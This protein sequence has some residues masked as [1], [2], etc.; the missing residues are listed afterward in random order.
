MVSKRQFVFIQIL[1]LFIVFTS[2]YLLPNNFVFAQETEYLYLGGQIVGID[3]SLN[4]IE[5]VSKSNVISQNGYISPF[6]NIDLYDGDML[7]SI[8]NEEVKNV[9]QIEKL[10]EGK[11]HSCVIIK[12]NNKALKYTINPQF[13]LISRKNKLGLILKDNISGIGTITYINPKDLSFAALGH[14]IKNSQG[15]NLI[16]QTGN[17]YPINISRIVKPTKNKAGELVGGISRFANPIGQIN[18]SNDYGIFGNIFDNN[19]N[20]IKIQKANMSDVHLGMAQICSNIINN[21]PS[22]FDIEILK[23]DTNSEKSFVVK[24][25]DERL[26]ELTGGIVQGMS[27]SPI[28]QNGKLIGA[29][30][31]VLINN[32]T[33]G[34]GIFIEKMM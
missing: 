12:R 28:L 6:E 30:T 11:K 27:G 5:I 20:F 16:E 2:L 34:Y 4:G 8:D 31:H 19:E 23:I 1:I 26:L 18:N 22:F 13:D 9:S 21:Q 15:E 24:I 25:V 33:K 14:P 3:I 10:L 7:F 32:P 29:I 17:I